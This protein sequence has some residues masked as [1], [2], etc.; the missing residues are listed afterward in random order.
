MSERTPV[1]RVQLWG[2][3]IGAVAWDPARGLGAFE[4]EPAFLESGI[5][6]A[7]LKM[8]LARAIYTF[9]EL[10]RSTFRGL[11]G[12]LADALPDRFGDAL[13]DQWL[14]RQGRDRASFTPV[15]RLAYVGRRGMGA[16][17]FRPS[18]RSPREGAHPLALDALVDLANR[19]LSARGELDTQLDADGLE[20]ILRVGTSAGG[21]RAKA[22]IAWNP[23]TREVR[24]GQLA[25]PPGFEHWL[26]KFD[27]VRANRDKE[28]LA[29]PLGYGLV[30]LAYSRMARRAGLAMAP[31]E[32][33]REGGRAHFMTRRFDRTSTGGK[34]HMQSLCAL[35]HHDFNHAGGT[36]YEQALALMGALGLP[37]SD[38]LQQFRRMVFNVVARNQDDHTKNIALL[39]DR[40]GRWSLSPAFDVTWAHNPRG[41]WTHQ[42]QMSLDGKR[43]GFVLE[44]LL[45]VGRTCGVRRREVRRILDEVCAAVRLW[46]DLAGELG[47]APERIAAIAAT[48]R[49]ELGERG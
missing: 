7:P 27:G 29:D 15:E 21:A 37:R 41:D 33:L 42:H 38:L 49:L 16:L 2:A 45:A 23:E 4:Y 25:A 10:P 8:P 24:S 47:L 32:L 31:C 1:V 39:M 46:P 30:E 13:I 35:G 43:D 20:D 34:L 17:E 48:H 28:A 5:E 26:L 40:R 9:P 18:L 3:D 44:D 14:A 22:V 6:L 19:V 11:P 12:L 36:A